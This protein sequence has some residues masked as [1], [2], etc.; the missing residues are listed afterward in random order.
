MLQLDGYI[1]STTEEYAND[2][3]F[4]FKDISTLSTNIP[5]SSITLNTTSLSLY[6]GDIKTITATILPANATETI[7]WSSSHPEIATV[8]NGEI[9][10]KS[11]G[12]TT[13]TVSN[14]DGTIKTACEVT[15]TKKNTLPDNDNTIKDVIKT[16]PTPYNNTLTDNTIA[17]SK[18]PSAGISNFLLIS[19]F[20]VF[21]VIFISYKKYNNLKNI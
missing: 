4:T 15:V 2:N 3:G 11:V 16:E 8:N 14:L 6:V 12:S 10:A 18:L 1:N 7:L 17:D 21:F 9:T 19:L 13:I 5:I 20:I